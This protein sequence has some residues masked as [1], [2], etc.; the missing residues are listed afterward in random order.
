MTTLSETLKK[1]NRNGYSTNR[2]AQLATARGY[3]LSQPTVSRYL[4]GNHP[5][6]PDVEVL[7]AFSTV[8]G[9]SVDILEKAA[10]VAP[11]YERFELPAYADKLDQSE[12]KAVV[13]IVRLMAENKTVESESFHP[14][15]SDVALAADEE[16]VGHV[17]RR[18][19][20]DALGEES[21]EVGEV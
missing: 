5:E 6:K 13:E 21:Q 19:Y 16:N 11:T 20:F 9:V 7:K 3:K 4:S 8:L 1:N 17:R 12:R 10:G 14:E 2:I 18:E 15:R